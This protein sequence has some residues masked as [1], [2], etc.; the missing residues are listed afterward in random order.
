MNITDIPIPY[1]RELAIVEIGTF[2][3]ARDLLD[4][5]KGNGC[6][7]SDPAYGILGSPFFKLSR[8]R[9]KQQ[10]VAIPNSTIRLN[11]AITAEQAGEY[12]KRFGLLPCS[13]ETA[14]QLMIQS[15]GL[16]SDQGLGPLL[17][18]MEPIM[19]PG[20]GYRIWRA[21]HPITE[22]YLGTSGFTD[23]WFGARWVFV[24]P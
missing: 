6:R 5:M 20:T 14:P 12:G 11:S 8:E 23:E 16:L 21:G 13:S 4:A 24:L 7:L 3:G 19:V 10:L 18:S 17:F 2:S 15:I 22:R 9:R 1:V